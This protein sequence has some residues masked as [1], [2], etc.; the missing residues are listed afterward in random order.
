MSV[1]KK[2]EKNRKKRERFAALSV[3]EKEAHRKKNRDAYHRRKLSKLLSKPLAEQS[4]QISRPSDTPG[5]GL[6]AISNNCADGSYFHRCNNLLPRTKILMSELSEH[7]RCVTCMFRKLRSPFLFFCCLHVE[8]LFTLYC[9]S[10]SSWKC[11]CS[12][13]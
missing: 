7:G 8:F 2:S 10:K 3:E 12:E 13:N 9:S 4:Q 5:S 11:I 6:L 1:R